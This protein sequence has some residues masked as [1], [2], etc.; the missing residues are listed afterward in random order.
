MCA[1]DFR[2]SLRT[3]CACDRGRRETLRSLQTGCASHLLRTR[4]YSLVEADSK[5]TIYWFPRRSR[6]AGWVVKGWER[7]GRAIPCGNHAAL[8]P[9]AVLLMDTVHSRGNALS[10]TDRHAAPGSQDS[11]C[12][13]AGCLSSVHCAEP[14]RA[15]KIERAVSSLGQFATHTPGSPHFTGNVCNESPCDPSSALHPG[16]VVPTL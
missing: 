8:S 12:Q 11:G 9:C 16:T 14:K 6:E 3:V 7:V 10:E 15:I 1:R 4:W 2:T 5:T 13:D